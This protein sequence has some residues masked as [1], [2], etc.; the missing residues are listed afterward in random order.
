MS[1]DKRPE[2]AA[3][4]KQLG[5][6]RPALQPASRAE[7]SGHLKGLPSDVGS[8]GAWFTCQAAAFLPPPG[9]YHQ[10]RKTLLCLGVSRVVTDSLLCPLRLPFSVSTAGLT[11]VYTVYQDL[12]FVT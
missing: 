5:D 6:R 3:F 11:P 2:R 1:Q 4:P 7:A 10:F 12:F 8:E 9:K